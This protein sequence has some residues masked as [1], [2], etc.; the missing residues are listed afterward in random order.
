MIQGII[1]MT[2]WFT[3]ANTGQ[4]KPFHQSCICSKTMQQ[5]SLTGHRLAT[6]FMES[7][8]LNP[9]IKYSGYCREHTAPC[10]RPRYVCA[11]Y[12]KKEHYR[13]VHPDAKSLKHVILKRKQARIQ[14]LKEVSQTV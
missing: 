1:Y 2:Y 10:N 6:V 13:L 12:A 3:I 8:V 14:R 7:M 9:F 11:E 4:R 5:I